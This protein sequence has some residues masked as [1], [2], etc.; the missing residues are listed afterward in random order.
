MRIVKK[1]EEETLY[2][3]NLKSSS[4]QIPMQDNE[5]K[6]GIFQG[7]V[8]IVGHGKLAATLVYLY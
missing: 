7:K 2:R 4:P 5:M 3:R 8:V 6:T 1:F